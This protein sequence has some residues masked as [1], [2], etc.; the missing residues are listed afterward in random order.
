[1]NKTII[2]VISV[3]FIAGC[4]IKE[5]S[6][7]VVK[8]DINTPIK[9][10]SKTKSNKILKV[11]RF[12]TP[13]Y[14]FGNKI[15]YQ[16]DSFKTNSYLY[17]S[18]N[19]DF[20]SMIEQKVANTLYKSSLFK[21]VFSKYSKAKADIILE[22]EIISALQYVKKESA[23]VVFEIR[24]YLIDS[25]RSKIIGSKDFSYKKRCD[26]VDAPGAVKAYNRIIKTFSKEVVLWLKK[27][28]KED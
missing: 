28:V 4:S 17:S 9:I 24:L 1:M 3:F 12:K 19:Q 20:S 22:G 21:S 11:S 26:T 13:I 25:K 16:R 14:L 5:V 6:K 10:S 23:Y 7:P 8:Y 2:F 15:W 27:L 18:W